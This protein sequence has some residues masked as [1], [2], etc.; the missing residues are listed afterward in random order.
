MRKGERV[1]PG[2]LIAD[3][4][5]AP[6]ELEPRHS[7]TF[8]AATLGIPYSKAWDAVKWREVPVADDR[9]SPK[10]RLSDMRRWWTQK[11]EASNA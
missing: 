8:C 9:D 4:A 10:V 3:A 11:Q 5:A 7:V 2:W 1:A 6:P